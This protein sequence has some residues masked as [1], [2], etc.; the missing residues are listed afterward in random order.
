LSIAILK[1][2]TVKM[3]L[4]RGNVKLPIVDV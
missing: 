4:S 1:L 3:K 2:S